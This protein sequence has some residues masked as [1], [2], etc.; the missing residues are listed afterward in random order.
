[1]PKFDVK[2]A[3]GFRPIKKQTHVVLPKG[4]LEKVNQLKN[5]PSAIHTATETP[6]TITG[7]NSKT[8]YH[9][10]YYYFSF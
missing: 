6:K 1:M 9:C 4:I 5:A 3:A 2:F 7:N 10:Y 8:F